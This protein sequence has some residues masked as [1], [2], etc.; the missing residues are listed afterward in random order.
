M[1]LAIS[2]KREYLADAS[3]VEITRNPDGLIS[4]LKTISEDPLPTQ[5]ANKSTAHLYMVN[6][7]KQNKD[8]LMSTHPTIE[9]RIEAL[10]NIK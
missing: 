8:S 5:S 9:N 4:A 6:P 1:Q 2:R 10:K 7:F 3:A